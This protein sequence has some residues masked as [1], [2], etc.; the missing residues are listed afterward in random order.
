MGLFGIGGSTS[1]Q[2]SESSS[3][4]F[5][6][7]DAFGFNFA[8]D[9]SSSRGGSSSSQS[10]AFQDVFSKLFGG[11]S[12]A[13]AGVDTSSISNA[14]SLLFGKG[15][16]FLEELGGGGVGAR[17]LEDRL[18][19]SDE[20]AD[21]EIAG[22]ES[23]IGRFLSE[24]ANPA[25]TAGGVS[26]GTFGGTRGEVQRGIATRGATEAFTRG[27][28]DIRARHRGET[29]ALATALAGDETARNVSG[30]ESLPGLFGLAEGGELAGLSPFAALSQ[31]IG[32]PT[33]LTESE[34]SQLAEAL[35]T[36]FGLDRTTGRA[37]S[38]STSSS[39]SS[40]K[41]FNLGFG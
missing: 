33:V 37:A 17:F 27:A 26:A 2:R 20:L 23:D 39:S 15:G 28:T 41:S 14:A 8:R 34:S 10:I 7:L 30:L 4:S 32:G 6:N 13:A 25:I 21:Q 35:A 38:R 36:Q 24:T 29:D 31:I 1:K 11:A 12:G 22:L 40:A 3:S 5:D 18:A 16:D 9:T 19:G